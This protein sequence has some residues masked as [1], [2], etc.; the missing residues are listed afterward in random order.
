MN[1]GPQR[2]ATAIRL[3]LEQRAPKPAWRPS[4][5]QARPLSQ[6]SGRPTGKDRR[7]SIA[8]RSIG[9]TQ[10]IRR[11]HDDC[12]HRHPRGMSRL[13][14]GP[15]PRKSTEPPSLDLFR[16][17]MASAFSDVS[18][19][20]SLAKRAE[21]ALDVS[22]LT[23]HADGKLVRGT[24]PLQKAELCKEYGL[25]ARDLRLLDGNLTESSPSIL[26]RSR[27]IIYS[28]AL[29]QAIITPDKL[30]LFDDPHPPDVADLGSRLRPDS[31]SIAKVREIA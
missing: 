9:E 5:I 17:E 18:G 25:Q 3:V 26:V 22:T 23:L 2:A 1:A 15:P 31:A 11:T 28:S 21:T 6:L 27:S 14:A 16:E 29:I 7:P 30:V 19:L 13:L 10:L 20:E 4:S 12:H 24:G 8:H